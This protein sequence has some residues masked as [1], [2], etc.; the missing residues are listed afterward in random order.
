MPARNDIQNEILTAKNA[1]VTIE[2][3][4]C[5]KI[6]ENHNGKGTYIQINLK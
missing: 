6:I 4:N 3:T 5:I 1:I 2:V